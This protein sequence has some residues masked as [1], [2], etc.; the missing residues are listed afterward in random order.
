MTTG[1][2]PGIED[3]VALIRVSLLALAGAGVSIAINPLAT[4]SLHALARRIQRGV[5]RDHASVTRD[6]AL[7]LHAGAQAE[8]VKVSGGWW[9]GSAVPVQ[10]TMGKISV[11]ACRAL[12]RT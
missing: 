4:F 2:N 11:F 9:R 10:T 6:I 1:P 3:G 12:L 7:C 5:G 8:G